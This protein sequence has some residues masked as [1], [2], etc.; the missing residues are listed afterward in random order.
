MLQRDGREIER[1]MTPVVPPSQSRFEI[2]DIGV[3]PDVHPHLQSVSPGE[4]AE[5]AGLKAGDVILAV[6]GQPI[7]FHSQF[8]EAIAKHPEQPMTLT[9]LRD[10]AEQQHRGDAGQTRRPSGGSA[11]SRSTRAFASRRVRSRPSS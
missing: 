10:G 9:V 3:L 4:P 5:R 2:G 11:C 1:T 8:R 6:D 7:T